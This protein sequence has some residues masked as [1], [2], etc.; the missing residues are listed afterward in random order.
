MMLPLAPTL[1]RLALHMMTEST[2][3]ELNQE[4]LWGTVSH[5]NPTPITRWMTMVTYFLGDQIDP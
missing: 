5:G 2:K 1:F 3:S 4:V